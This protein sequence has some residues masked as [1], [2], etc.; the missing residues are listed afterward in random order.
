M[1]DVGAILLWWKWSKFIVN[2]DKN[3]V[4]STVYEEV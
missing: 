1:Y 2:Q 3:C 4:V